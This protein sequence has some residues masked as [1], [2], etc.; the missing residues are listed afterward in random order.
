M[1]RDPGAHGGVPARRVVVRWAWRMFRREWRQQV[2]VVALITVAVAIAVGGAT[3]GYNAARSEDGHFGT[4]DLRIE[5]VVDNPEGMDAYLK[6]AE[7]WFGTID[8]IAWRSVSVS[9]AADDLEL[10]AQDPEGAYSGP[11]L[12]LREGRYP[13]DVGELAL[14]NGDAQTFGVTVGD[15]IALESDS[16][17]NGNATE[18]DVVGLVENPN[19]L[20]EEFGLV[21]PSSDIQPTALTLLV[22]GSEDR[23]VEFPDDMDTGPGYFDS[24]D[25]TV[26]ATAGAGALAASTVVMLLVC[27]VAAAGFVVI[28]QRRQRQLGM[29]AS[30]GATQKHL[31]LVVVANGAIV[32]A[33]AAVVGAVL[34]LGVWIVAAPGLEGVAQHRVDRFNVSWWLVGLGMALA[35]VAATAAAWWPSRTVARVPVV[36]ALSGRPPRPRA[37]RR[38]LLL[39]VPL[40]IVGVV[41]LLVGIEEPEGA[42]E[43]I[44]DLLVISGILAIPLGIALVGP[45]VVGTLAPIAKRFPVATRLSLRDLARYQARSGAALAA[46]S[47]GLGIAVAVVVAASAAEY[48]TDEGNLSDRQLMIRAS[49]LDGGWLESVPEQTPAEL[50]RLETSVDQVAETLDDPTVLALDMP[51]D[52][53]V[54]YI[55]EARPGEPGS[56]TVEPPLGLGRPVD[57]DTNRDL[58]QFYVATP[59]V[60]E[61]LGL[62]DALVNSG[63][64]VLTT[65]TG[66]LFF[67]QVS[68]SHPACEPDE[69]E[70]NCR[71][72]VENATTIDVAYTSTP[73]SLITPEAV[74]RNGWEIA[75]AAW[76][77]EADEPLTSDQLADV[78]EAAGDVGLFVET[79]S[80]QEGLT[81]LRSGATG[82]GLLLGLGILAM[83]V[84]L[85]RTETAGDL[86][87]LTATGA[88][89]R[90]RRTVTGVTAGALAFLG[91]LLGTAGAYM[92]LTAGYS[93]DLSR[94]NP[95]PVVHLLVIILGLPAVAAVAGWL[96]AGR[97]PPVIA[98]QLLE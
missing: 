90:V 25:A 15:T 39:A 89:S 20:S 31:R 52:P 91:A 1:R 68:D 38:T 12:D 7:E 47:L 75:R 9:G 57:E 87:T 62:D 65:Y 45:L 59:Q 14:T 40:I 24:R 33:V 63:A 18:W 16:E 51:V 73:K 98:R 88:S 84:G 35:V 69:I 19:D 29:L 50:E 55:T 82:L 32:G 60:L 28:A 8:V 94:L 21:A 85:I 42:D 67:H 13:T 37:A 95:V 71:A 70:G 11:M 4:A 27:L 80:G 76:L 66:D 5:T 86:R 30:I 6:A 54:G 36:R 77:G 22:Q 2:L 23:A 93:D 74:E 10:R 96:L 64:E 79:R 48:S 46:I 97:E 17:N 3:A 92:A 53:G 61:H 81:Q 26:A 83:T 78:R 34:G 56:R 43:E 49:E 58:G 41:C 44:N 72:P